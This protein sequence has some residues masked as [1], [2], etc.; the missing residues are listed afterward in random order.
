MIC[1]FGVP[2][3]LVANNGTQFQNKK[4]KELCDIYHIKL[5]FA[6]MSY[7]QSKGQAEATNKVILNNIR[8]NLEEEDGQRNYQGCYGHIGPQ[9]DI[10]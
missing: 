7:P 10:L 4:L 3:E 2:R 6:S 8:K 9:K 1:Q 5:N